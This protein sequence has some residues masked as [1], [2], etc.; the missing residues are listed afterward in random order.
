MDVRDGGAGS[1]LRGIRD[2]VGV[3]NVV[4]VARQGECGEDSVSVVRVR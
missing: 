3:P 2:G 4:S 1:C